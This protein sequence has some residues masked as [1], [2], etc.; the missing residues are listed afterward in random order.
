MTPERY[1]RLRAVL[2]RRQP[3]LTVV[4]DRVHKPHNL[5]A[6]LR[7]GDAVG[8]AEAHAV[9][10]TDYI[11]RKPTSAAGTRR[12]VQVRRHRRLEEAL[13]LLQGQGFQVVAAHLS[14]QTVDY[15]EVDYTRPTALLFGAELRGVSA[16]AA[17]RA[18]VLVRIPMRGMVESLNVSVAASLL[19]YEAA[20]QREAAGLYDRPHLP[21]E[22]Y[23]RLLFEWGYPEVAAHCRSHGLAY[24]A[25]DEEGLVD[26]QAW[27]TAQPGG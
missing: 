9:R 27:Q 7:T 3:D 22:E 23:R 20:R 14:E 18:D 10:A 5:A 17:G 26:W 11:H 8:V 16:E 19:L 4:L 25:L 12:W 21:E 2:D 24:P 1:A 15:R 6:I 13:D